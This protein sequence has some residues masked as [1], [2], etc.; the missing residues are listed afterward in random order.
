M[1]YIELVKEC[2]KILETRRSGGKVSLNV[3]YIMY[4]S[5]NYN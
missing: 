5:Y 1:Q 4:N 3:L 2:N